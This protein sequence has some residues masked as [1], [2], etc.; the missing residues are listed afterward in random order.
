MSAR[1]KRIAVTLVVLGVIG[2]SA[3]PAGAVFHGHNG[4]VLVTTTLETESDYVWGATWLAS[5]GQRPVRLRLPGAD[6]FPF[7]PVV[8][9]DGKRVAY[10]NLGVLV[11]RIGGSGPAR[12][13]TR[14]SDFGPAWS[15]RGGAIAFLREGDL[16]GA[17]LYVVRAHEGGLRR[18]FGS[19]ALDFA[20]SP[21][22]TRLAVIAGDRSQDDPPESPPIFVVDLHGAASEIARGVQVS[23]SRTNWLAYRRG[24]GLYVVRPDGSQ[25]RLIAQVGQPNFSGPPYAWSPDG[26]RIAFSRDGRIFVTDVGGGKP[27]RLTS[28][29]SGPLTF[30][31]D[32]RLI[33]FTWYPRALADSFISILVVKPVSGG[34]ARVTPIHWSGDGED[35]EEISALDWQVRQRAR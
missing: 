11:S 27:R 20:W 3:V 25:K 1:I 35:P 18:V 5:D 32:G 19:A 24:S 21:D 7:T 4:K 10:A 30:S 17:G 13:L 28:S 2:A 22:A 31:P 33:A 9:P 15:P 12:R 8:S 29:G 16:S 34:R 6:Y 26:R 23:W 14:G